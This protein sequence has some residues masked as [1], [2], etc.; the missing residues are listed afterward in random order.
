MFEVEVQAAKNFVE[1]PYTISLKNRIC[2]KSQT[3]ISRVQTNLNLF[4]TRKN[5]CFFLENTA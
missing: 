1:Q 4:K 3:D 5:F 2:L